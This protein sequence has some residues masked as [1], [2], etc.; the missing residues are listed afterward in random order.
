M[1]NNSTKYDAKIT[2][3]TDF[4]EYY[5]LAMAR[6]LEIIHQLRMSNTPTGLSTINIHLHSIYKKIRSRLSTEDVKKEEQYIMELKK[7]K[8]TKSSIK[9]V[10][11][12]MGSDV[13]PFL[14]IEKTEDYPKYERLIEDREIHIWDC[15]NKLELTSKQARKDKHII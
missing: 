14:K 11:S 12:V 13:N 15:L 8:P 10:G 3:A 7:L 9:S 4:S 2:M 6:S 5:Q 1:D